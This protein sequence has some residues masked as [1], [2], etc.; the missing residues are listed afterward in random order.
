MRLAFAGIVVAVIAT[1]CASGGG[2]PS[3]FPAV[4][5]SQIRALKITPAS[6]S[7]CPG[8][9]VPVQYAAV[10]TDGT[11]R[12]FASRGTTTGGLDPKVLTF[13]SPTATMGVDGRMETSADPLA[14]V[15]KGFPIR[16]SLVGNPSVSAET[17]IVPTYECLPRAITAIGGSPTKVC[18]AASNGRLSDDHCDLVPRIARGSKEGAVP[19]TNFSVLLGVVRTPFFDSLLVGVV[20]VP[21][22]RPI[23]ML[24]PAPIKPGILMVTAPGRN[25][26]P[27]MAGRGGE[28]SESCSS[29]G[30]GQNGEDGHPGGDGPT[31]SL[32]VQDDNEALQAVVIARL[33]GGQ[34]GAGGPGGQ[35]GAGGVEY[36]KDPVTGKQSIKCRGTT[37]GSNGA[38]GNQGVQGRDGSI[39]SGAL[40]LASLFQQSA[41]WQDPT[42]RAELSELLEYAAR[43]AKSPPKK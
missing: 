18:A 21:G 37:R 31:L 25:G 35:G 42:R 13:A 38:P 30:S 27:G 32:F 7:A 41:L 33:E 24:V 16:V 19:A 10:F 8:G 11:E 4:D 26:T 36:N 20:D 9:V 2:L 17:T 39:A 43:L 23:V 14:S 1:A 5:V 29:G 22:D 15:I 12:V 40:P 6:N 3:S 28:L 34:G